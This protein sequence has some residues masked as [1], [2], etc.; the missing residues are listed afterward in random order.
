M[1]CGAL[2]VDPVAAVYEQVLAE[3]VVPS[4]HRVVAMADVFMMALGVRLVHVHA[5]GHVVI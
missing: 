1:V 4:V 5:L 3:S 2:H